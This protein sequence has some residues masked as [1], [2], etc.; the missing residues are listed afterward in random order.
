MAFPSLTTFKTELCVLRPDT[1]KVFI[2]RHCMMAYYV[3]HSPHAIHSRWYIL[4]TPYNT[5]LFNLSRHHN[6]LAWQRSPCPIQ[7]LPPSRFQYSIHAR[8]MPLLTGEVC[9]LYQI[10]YQIYI[11]MIYVP[12]FIQHLWTPYP[13]SGLASAGMV[14]SLVY[15][16]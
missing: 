10:I 5:L 4:T 11:H 3:W 2:T 12:S 16:K 7:S 6:T 1:N 9:M 15:L 8:W 13:P 14:M